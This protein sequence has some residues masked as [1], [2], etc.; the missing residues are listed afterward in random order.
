LSHDAL[1]ATHV[2]ASG[3]KTASLSRKSTSRRSFVLAGP[4]AHGQAP[5]ADQVGEREYLIVAGGQIEISQDGNGVT[6]WQRFPLGRRTKRAPDGA[7]AA[8]L[9]SS[10]YLPR[11]ERPSRR[12][13]AAWRL[14]S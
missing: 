11:R 7:R 13:V 12:L 1:E 10:S 9:R 8:T 4:P 5:Q 3:R 14:P 6:R 2:L